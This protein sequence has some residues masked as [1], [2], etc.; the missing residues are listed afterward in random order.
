MCEQFVVYLYQQGLRKKI[1]GWRNDMLGSGKKGGLTPAIVIFNDFLF[2]NYLSQESLGGPIQV[3]QR[4]GDIKKQKQLTIPVFHFQHQI[5]S[6]EIAIFSI[7]HQIFS[8]GY[9]LI[10]ESLQI[11]FAGF[12]SRFLLIRAFDTVS[13]IYSFAFLLVVIQD[14]SILLVYYI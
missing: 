14:N 1:M 10:I 7:S 9:D 6:L 8:H 11:F 12:T 5:Y 13:F 4:M 3:S 2:N